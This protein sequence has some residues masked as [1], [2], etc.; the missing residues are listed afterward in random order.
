MVNKQFHHQYFPHIDG[1]RALAIIPVVVYH[2][3]PTLCP[4]GFAGVD[5]FFVISG[6][7]ITGGIVADLNNGQ[8][9]ISN[10]YVRRIKRILPAYFAIIAFVLIIFPLKYSFPQYSSICKTAVYSAFYS[11][12]I[13]FA[14]IISYFDVGARE[15]P[16]LHLWSLGVEEQF[17]LVVPVFIWILWIVRKKLILQNLIFLFL[18]SFISSLWSISNGHP[19]FA[20]FMLPS[21]AWELL[22]GAI[23]SQ[24]N[25]T[26]YT[27]PAW[28]FGHLISWSGLILVLIPYVLYNEQTPFPGMAAIP[29]IL[30]A[31]LIIL[32]GGGRGL[33]ELLSSSPAVWVGKVS[34]SLYLWHWPI[35]VLLGSSYTV[36]RGVAGIIT[37]ILASYLSYRFIE[38]PVRRCKTFSKR[39][40]F[41]MLITGSLII[42]I[43]CLSVLVQKS[44]NGELPASWEGKA[45]WAVAEQSRDKSRST[46]RIEDLNAENSRFLIKIGKSGKPPTFALWGDSHA[47]AIMPGVDIVASEYGKSGYYIN[48]KQSLTLNRDI[49]AYPFNP[50]E[51]REPVIIWLENHHDISDV[52]L[53]NRW[54]GHIRNNSDIEETVK[55]CE[56]LHKSGKRVFFFVNM[57][58]ANQKALWRLSWGLRVNSNLSATS[59]ADYES[60][61]QLQHQLINELIKRDV[62]TVLTI[63]KAFFNGMAYYST[64]DTNSFYS[65]G[66]HLNQTGAVR[67]MEFV[68]PL[69]WS[70]RSN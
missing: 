22:A 1:L 64:T 7:L 39:H 49:G 35:F 5:V 23:V 15:N 2:L 63:D 65:D 67:A 43:V 8:Y 4:G 12:N 54:F 32:Y 34:Y 42:T 25:T 68:A 60:Q 70:S 20:F 9:S 19:Q 16:L 52:F 38:L 33:N 51:D 40:A 36:Q 18:L 56:R 66:N 14:N 27:K 17:Y 21:R 57:P 44:K 58:D 28:S 6:Y 41:T 11:A 48:L 46:C 3:F 55:I 53:V 37:T 26:R 69:I 24:I 10:F 13:Y 31:S 30:G 47:L 45:T 50:R 62:A 61:A 29:S 59:L